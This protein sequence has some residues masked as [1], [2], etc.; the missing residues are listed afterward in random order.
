ASQI[1]GETAKKLRNLEGIAN[2]PGSGAALWSAEV[3]SIQTKPR[4]G[5]EASVNLIVRGV[6]PEGRALRP[7][8]KLIEGRDLNPGTNEAITSRSMAERFQNC[9]LGE[10]LNIHGKDFEV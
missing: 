6:T 3:V 10:K 8:F 5:Q 2:D 7:D 9:G 4:R 1:E